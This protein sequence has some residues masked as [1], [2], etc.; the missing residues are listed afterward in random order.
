[1]IQKRSAFQALLLCASIMP[2]NQS[3]KA[4]WF[5][6]SDAL[7]SAHQRLLEGNTAASFESMVEAWQQ[8]SIDKEQKHHLAGLLSLAVT[9]D[10]G[11]SLSQLSLPIWLDNLV[12]RRETVQTTSRIYYRVMISGESESGVKSITL[13]KW[14]DEV[15]MEN[16]LSDEQQRNFKLELD[17]LSEPVAE[18]LY[19]VSAESTSGE[20][21]SSW[22]LMTLPQPLQKIGWKDS[23]SWRISPPASLKSTCQKPFLA[24]N[25]YRQDEPGSAP[26]WSAEK[27]ENLPTSLP[28]LDV[29]NGQYWFSVALI[30]RRWQ[31]AI[32]LEEV[33]RI[34][35]SIDLPDIDPTSFRILDN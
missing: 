9:E 13:K 32:S 23:R 21:W 25:L 34:G 15:V 30:E 3:A 14:P 5:N 18:G 33:Q 19:Q 29:P 8:P 31:G 26:M 10:C 22:I 20:T 35:R 28:V 7:T 12:L 11:R 16:M 1:M 6:G 24:L 2:L 27:H 4:A 17:G